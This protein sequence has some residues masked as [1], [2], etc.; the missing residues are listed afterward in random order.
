MVLQDTFLFNGSIAMNIAYGSPNAS[1]EDIRRAARDAYADA[2]ISAMP[3][4]YDTI[5]GERGVRLS[6]WQKQ[7]ISIARAILRNTPI[8]ILDEATSSVDTETES[9]IQKAIDNFS[10]S[11]TIIIIAHR[12]STV[13]RADQILVMEKGRVSE[14]GTHEELLKMGG[15]YAR[16]VKLQQKDRHPAA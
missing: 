13:K 12:L 4:G 10:G 5:V 2:F 1:M 14:Q 7:R 3:E 16:M 11:R 6:G 9:E 8:L 15:L